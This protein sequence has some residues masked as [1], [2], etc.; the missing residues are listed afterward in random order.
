MAQP[1]SFLTKAAEG[2]TY[3]NSFRPT[4]PRSVQLAL[5][6]FGSAG[7]LALTID[8]VITI[9]GSKSQI[10]YKST[11]GLLAMS[12]ISFAAYF[13]SKTEKERDQV[14]VL[15]VEVGV[16][17]SVMPAQARIQF[18]APEEPDPSLTTCKF[19]LSQAVASTRHLRYRIADIF[20]FICENLKGKPF[21]DTPVLK[22]YSVP[23]N[24]EE[25]QIFNNKETA[26]HAEKGPFSYPAS[27]EK[28]VH[29]TTFYGHKDDFLWWQDDYIN[30]VNWQFLQFPGLEFLSTAC[31]GKNVERKLE[32]D[33]I[34]LITGVYRHADLSSLL[35]KDVSDLQNVDIPKELPF[36]NSPS[37]GKLFIL[38][39][40]ETIT[41]AN[42][43]LEDVTFLYKSAY[44]AFYQIKQAHKNQRV[45][46][47][48]G[49]WCTDGKTNTSLS[50][51]IQ[52]LAAQ[53]AGIDELHYYGK[54]KK[55][56][57][58]EHEQVWNRTKT[59]HKTHSTGAILK[60]LLSAFQIAPVWNETIRTTD[61]T[62]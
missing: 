38:G 22:I 41:E 44:N 51:L 32:K 10:D 35:S 16:P 29:W 4:L 36:F 2:V 8:K 55:E 33:E 34:A 7:T 17:K 62:I 39:A 27:T 37:E 57:L 59:E 15:R 6:A 19:H 60:Q 18:K 31:K 14:S 25:I 11:W 5:L 47:H 12:V 3:L 61:W 54:S 49:L 26:F 52:R 24:W 9:L 42:V 58:E 13:F 40:L 20:Q 48:T 50:I 43:S 23:S 30:F 1:T 46:I 21:P 28:E 45:V 56:H 53:A